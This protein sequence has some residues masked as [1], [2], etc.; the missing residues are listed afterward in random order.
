MDY[1][2]T[3]ASQTMAYEGNNSVGVN[4]NDLINSSN[5]FSGVTTSAQA[6]KLGGEY[7]IGPV[8]LRAGYHYRKS[9]YQQPE[10]YRGDYTA[11]SGGLGYLAK[12]FGIDLAVVSS[13]Y[14][15]KDFVH[16]FLYTDQTGDQL[17]DS[18]INR[19]NVILGFNL[20][21]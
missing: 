16:P 20:R 17:V 12:N 2:Y 21:F 8:A 5:T 11:I 9:F 19:L 7:R 18:Q 15:R 6:I 10:Y 14:N 13:S 4:D 1:E 3:D